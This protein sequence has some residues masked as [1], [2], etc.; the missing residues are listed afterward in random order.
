M[1]LVVAVLLAGVLSIAVAQGDYPN[2]TIKIVVPIP[3]GGTADVLPRLVA[4]KLSARWSQ[5]VIVE[6]R[7]GAALNLGAEAVAKAEPDGYTL[8]ATPPGPLVTNRFLSPH[9]GFDPSAFVPVTVL[10]K[11]PFLLIVRPNLPVSSL[12][13][14]I[15]YAKAN[16]DKLNFASSGTG[17]PPHLAM[18]MLKAKA[19]IRLVH[20]P[21]RGLTPALTDVAA[22]H[23]DMLFH[24]PSSTLPQIRS[25]HVKALAVS[26]A[27][28]IRELPDVPAIAET[29]GGFD[30]TT[31][32]A[33]VAPPKTPSNV[34]T[35]LSQAI[36]EIVRL[37]D[38]AKQLSDF[39]IAPG[40]STPA[41]TA[42][43]LKAET[44]LWRA[45]VVAAGIKPD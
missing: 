19:G 20:V 11:G 45:V 2:H 43:F 31:W 40:G 22:G 26:G 36:A 15:A 24:D 39:S 16:P 41:E 34:A 7:P 17:S 23:V 5:P 29:I 28:R 8:L 3:P 21:Y 12:Q 37:P 18:E 38:V 32:Y 10:A 4:E 44:E 27:S 42:A 1:M 33:V 9:L 35:K 13:E 14:F 30:V 25:G 6:N